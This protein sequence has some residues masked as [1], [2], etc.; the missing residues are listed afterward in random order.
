MANTFEDLGKTLMK[1]RERLQH[2][3]SQFANLYQD[4]S[5]YIVPSRRDVTRHIS[6]G[7]QQTEKIFD[8]TPV[9]SAA[10]A[11]AA[12]H[13]SMTPS[14]FKWFAMELA[15]NELGDVSGVDDWLY[16]ISTRMFDAINESNYH[17]E[18][19]EAWLDLFAYGTACLHVEEDLEKL[20]ARGD[21]AGLRFTAFQP[22]SFVFSENAQGIAD[23]IFRDFTLPLIA[24]KNKWGA[25]ALSVDLQRKLEQDSKLYESVALTHHVAPVVNIAGLRLRKKYASVYIERNKKHVLS[26]RG[27]DTFPYAVPRWAKA[28]GETYGRGPG[29]NAMPNVKTLNKAIELLLRNAA[30]RIDPPLEVISRNVIGD[31]GLAPA[32]WNSVKA[33]NS[34]SPIDVGGDLQ[35]TQIVLEDF[36][37]AVRR[38]FLV[39]QIQFPPMTGTPASATEIITRMELM[40]RIL[41]PVYGRVLSEWHA[42]MLHRIYVLMASRGALPP[43]PEGLG[44]ALNIRFTYENAL[45]RAQSLVDVEA[46]ERS[47]TLISA[48]LEAFPEMA[49]FFDAREAGKFI[50][51]AN[52]VPAI[53]IRDDDRANAA[54]EGR[55]EASEDQAATEDLG[56]VASAIS[57]L[58]PALQGFRE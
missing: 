54:R 12:A 16:E 10:L 13:G 8:S 58:T 23:T 55:M 49:D 25:K 22:G 40:R 57:D 51:K 45:S 7:T 46:V 18:G 9:D 30:K 35:L 34:I 1:R 3:F 47:M 11:A 4:V 37:A 15:N 52:R 17:A 19:Q 33:L 20:D 29:V 50:L 27:F 56:T 6:R 28:S 38:A 14:T 5:D 32:T 53:L 2:Q 26:V 41:G 39:D 42:V 48:F 44:D 36:R 21:F 31:I 43:P 24:V